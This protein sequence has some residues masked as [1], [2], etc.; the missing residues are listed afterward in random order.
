MGLFEAIALG[1]LYT[2]SVGISK[3]CMGLVRE[4]GKYGPWM[5]HSGVML[6]KV[7]DELM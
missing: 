5:S 1:H 7:Y 3:P 6:G 2:F 4:D